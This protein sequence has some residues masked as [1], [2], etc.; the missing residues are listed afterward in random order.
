MGNERLKRNLR[1]WFRFD[2]LPVKMGLSLLVGLS[3]NCTDVIDEFLDH[4]SVD[5]HFA[6]GLPLLDGSEIDSS[7]ST[8][9][10]EADHSNALVDEQGLI[11]RAR[12]RFR[13]YADFYE[14]LMAY[15]LSGKHPEVTPAAYFV[16]WA[17]SKHIDIGWFPVAEELALIPARVQSQLTR[18]FPERSSSGDKPLTTTERNTLLT[19]IAAL[20]DNSMIDYSKRGAAVRIMEITDEFGAHVDDGTIRNVLKQMPDALRTRL[21]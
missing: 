10:H 15:W 19:I 4:K 7:P 13:S 6:F 18:T 3:P 1:H 11:E 2:H 9:S 8:C 12:S 16:E 20:C 17:I 21:K 14:N 5:Y